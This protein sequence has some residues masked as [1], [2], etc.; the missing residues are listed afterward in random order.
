[1]YKTL[2]ECYEEVGKKLPFTV[3]SSDHPDFCL[4]FVKINPNDSNPWITL[5]GMPYAGTGRMWKLD[6]RHNT[7]TTTTG[8]Q[9]GDL[10]QV[11]G[12]PLYDGAI[13]TITR[14]ITHTQYQVKLDYNNS[15]E[16]F[17]S[18]ELKH[19]TKLFDAKLERAPSIGI[20]SEVE[21]PC[22]C[23]MLNGIVHSESCEYINWVRSK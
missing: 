10:V 12:F 21:P 22:H 6:P 17:L 2:Q 3:N 18:T 9:V 23:P 15:T 7:I 4:T 11:H 19:Y 14:I 5:D 13:G 8:F 20:R 16:L 1:M